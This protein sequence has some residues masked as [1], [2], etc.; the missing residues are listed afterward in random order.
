MIRTLTA[1]LVHE[2]HRPLRKLAGPDPA[3][4]YSR[5]DRRD[6]HGARQNRRCPFCRAWF[7][8]TALQDAHERDCDQRPTD[9]TPAEVLELAFPPHAGQLPDG[10]LIGYPRRGQLG[11]WSA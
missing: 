5:W 1:L 2:L 7:N 4:E 9:P 11:R 8:T 10:R 6:G 3:P